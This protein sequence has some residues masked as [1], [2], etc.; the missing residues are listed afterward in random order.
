[1]IKGDRIL[2]VGTPAGGGV[3][4]IASEPVASGDAGG[5]T[6]PIT[7]GLEFFVNP[8]VDVYSDAG[9]TPAVL[10][11]GVY[12]VNDQSSNGYTFSATT[13]INQLQYKPDGLGTDNASFY[14]SANTRWLD[15][16]STLNI[17]SSTDMTLHIVIN[18][19]STGNRLYGIGRYT[20]PNSGRSYFLDYDNGVVAIAD[21]NGTYVN[22]T[23]TQ[24]TNIELRSYV[25]DAASN[26]ASV[27]INGSL[28][29]TKAY[30]SDT[31]AFQRLY[32]HANGATTFRGHLGYTLFYK[33]AHS[34]TD[35]TTMWNWINTKYGIS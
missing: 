17:D 12:Q 11:D 16:G 8:D 19:D 29:Q 21:Q 33:S 23:T 2:N 3:S 28:I 20:L 6:P 5:D 35:I 7:T 18:R 10:D 9:S 24:T 32:N 22:I 30:S 31:F 13:A 1:M 15:W 4:I 27:Y 25:V 26:Q 14:V 34:S